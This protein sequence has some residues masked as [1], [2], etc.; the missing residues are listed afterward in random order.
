MQNDPFDKRTLWSDLR[1]RWLAPS[2]LPAD[3]H[4]RSDIGLPP[5]PVKQRIPMLVLAWSH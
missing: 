2:G 5:L 4:M 3:D 1:R